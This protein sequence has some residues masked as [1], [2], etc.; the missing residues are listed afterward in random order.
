[1]VAFNVINTIL[2]TSSFLKII[3]KLKIFSDSFSTGGPGK[4]MHSRTTK[5]CKLKQNSLIF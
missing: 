5:N 4:G 2:G 1:M 3:K